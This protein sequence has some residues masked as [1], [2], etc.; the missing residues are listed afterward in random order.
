MCASGYLPRTGEQA[1]QK[2]GVQ[3][4]RLE[5]GLG[6]NALVQRNGSLD[7]LDHEHF[8]RAAH[9]RN[10]LGAVAAAHDQLGDQRI[11][12]RRDHRVGMGGGVHAHARAAG[13]SE[14]W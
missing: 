5:I 6:K 13:Q 11:V 12:V 4:A 1:I 10:G 2:M 14:R 3:A 8:Q 7:A 9:A